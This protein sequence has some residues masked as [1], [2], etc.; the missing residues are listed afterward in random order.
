ML[1]SIATADRGEFTATTRHPKFKLR[2]AWNRSI[3][4]TITF[5][6]V[7]S[8]TVGGKDIVQGTQTVL[9]KPDL[10]NYTDETEKVIKIETERIL[11]EPLGGIA[12]A[13]A[14]I[15]LDNNDKRFTPNISATVGTALFPNR[16]TKIYLGL[17]IRDVD[18]AVPNVYGLTKMPR[19]NKSNR[20]LEIHIFDYLK[21][22]DEFA[23][24]STMYEDQRSDEIVADILVNKVGFSTDQMVLATGLNK[25]PFAWFEKDTTAGQAIRKICEAEEAILYQDETGMLKFE[26]RRKPREA[27]WNAA[28][29]TINPEDIL[30]WEELRDPIIINRCVVK[31]EP[32]TVQALDE[33]YRSGV[34]EEV[35]GNGSLEIWASFEDPVTLITDPV[36]NTDYVANAASDGSG[37]DM[38]SDISIVT[39]AFARNAKLVITNANSGAAHLT[40]LRL[41][42]TPA[43]ITNPIKKYF[44]DGASISKYDRHEIVIEND[45][46]NNES[47]AKYLAKTIVNKYSA[48]KKS[49]ILTV[50]AIPTLQLRDIITVKDKDQGTTKEY[51]V[52]RIQANMFPAA[53]TQ[54]I[55]LRE[56]YSEETDA[57]AIV[58]STIV[59]DIDELVGI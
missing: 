40:L 1:S 17:K 12:Y 42:G 18:K 23:L 29:Y 16:P 36:A 39:T 52:M 28:V 44:E 59:G 5:A 22:I 10:F 15:T 9:T 27:P 33:I 13:Q 35:P 49:L 21:F 26:T 51:R 11:E 8:S 46:I 55:T 3:D 6:V 47:F 14:D 58:D 48:P 34:I 4:N 37:A 50:P 45:F 7:D 2:I 19:E 25:I 24:E 32:R 54:R 30:L 53:Y 43:E 41:R 38:T 56:V 20:T 31:G 57:W